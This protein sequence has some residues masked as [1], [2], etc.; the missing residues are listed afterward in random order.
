M[1]ARE[2]VGVF[3]L[4]SKGQWAAKSTRLGGILDSG[5]NLRLYSA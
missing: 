5:R 4:Y 1:S 2:K 3:Q